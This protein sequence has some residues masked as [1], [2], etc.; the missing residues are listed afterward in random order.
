MLDTPSNSPSSAPDSISAL[1]QK[2]QTGLSGTTLTLDSSSIGVTGITNA[3]ETL[4]SS[5]SGSLV[6]D[7]VKSID[8]SP[9]RNTITLTPV[10]GDTLSATI[11]GSL[12]V[13]FASLS[14]LMEQTAIA[15]KFQTASQSISLSDLSSTYGIIP[16][17]YYG[18]T[19][20]SVFLND[21][22]LCFDSGS[23]SLGIKSSPLASLQPDFPSP[24]NSLKNVALDVLISQA[25]TTALKN[26]SVLLACTFE[27]VQGKDLTAEIYL[28]VG[29][30]GWRVS[31]VNSSDITLSDFL[32]ALQSLFSPDAL[33]YSLPAPFEALGNF[34][35]TDLEFQFSVSPAKI[36]R[37]SLQIE[38][39]NPWTIISK[40]LV[41][42]APVC[43]TL[44]IDNTHAT[45]GYSGTLTG[46]ATIANQVP[47]DVFIPIPLDSGVATISAQP[48]FSLGEGLSDL[49]ELVPE[50]FKWND[51]LPQSLLSDL[52]SLTLTDIALGIQFGAKAK[53]FPSLENFSLNID[54]TQSWSLPGLSDVSLQGVDASLDV[55]TGVN[56][57]QLGGAIQG[58]L[59]F[60]SPAIEIE[61][62]LSKPAGG[63]WS[64]SILSRDIVLPSLAQLESFVVGGS[65]PSS[66]LPDNSNAVSGL[67][68]DDLALDLSGGALQSFSFAL[69]EGGADSSWVILEH[70]FSIN[71]IYCSLNMEGDTTNGYIVAAATIL[72]AQVTF[73]AKYDSTESQW[74]FT[75]STGQINIGQFIAKLST[76]FSISLPSWINGIQIDSIDITFNSKT[77]GF[78]FDVLAALNDDYRAPELS[79]NVS[80]T[81]SGD[82][83]TKDFQGTITIPTQPANTVFTIEAEQSQGTKVEASYTGNGFSID[84]IGNL[85]D[86]PVTEIP[87]S[88]DL[89]L[90]DVTLSYDSS[91]H[92][93]FIGATNA[94]SGSAALLRMKLDVLTTFFLL[95][96][97]KSFSLSDLPLVGSELASIEN[98]EVN[99][100]ELLVTSA[101]T[102]S[103]DNIT[104]VNTTIN[105]FGTH[106]PV[107]PTPQ[108][109]SIDGKVTLAASLA[110]GGQIMHEVFSL[111]QQRQQQIPIN[112]VPDAVHTKTVA[113][114]AAA[115]GNN[116]TSRSLSDGTK[117]F[118]V[119]KSFGP[120]LIQKIGVRYN[121]GNQAL[122][123][124]IDSTL[125]AGPVALRLIGLGIGS[126]L[127]SFSPVFSLDGIG[128]SYDKPPLGISGTLI[129]AT[130]PGGDLAFEGEVTVGT[131]SFV[132]QCFG[133]YGEQSNF[134]SMFIFGDLSYPFGGPPSFFVNGAALGFGYNSNLRNPTMQDLSSFPFLEALPLSNAPGPNLFGNNPQ[135][136]QV[137]NDLM[138]GGSS[139]PWVSPV[140]SD[141]WFAGGITFNSFKLVNSEAMLLV[142]DGNELVLSL[143]GK[144]KASFP[145][146]SDTPY[147]QIE[148]DF[149]VTCT[150][151]QGTFSA[152]ALLS[153]NS[154]LF[155]PACVMTGGF[156]FD[157]WFGDNPHSGDFVLTLGGYNPMFVAPAYYPSVPQV[158]FHWPMDSSITIQGGAYFAM[159]PAVMM[160]GGVLD[161]SYQSGNLHAWFDAHADV[162]IQWKPF[163]FDA[164]I[165]IS[166]GASYRIDL[167][168][169]SF[170]VSIELSCGLELWGPPTGGQ[171]HVDWYIISFSIP[172]GNSN[173]RDTTT[174]TWSDVQA[175]LPVSGKSGT[176]STITPVA[177]LQAKATS[178]SN[179]PAAHPHHATEELES[180]PADPK[181]WVVRPSTFAFSTNVPVPSSQLTVGSSHSFEGDAVS[182]RP[183]NTSATSNDWHNI[184][185][186]HTITITASGHDRSSDFRVSLRRQNMPHSLWGDETGSTTSV[187]SG[188]EQM[189]AGQI[190]GATVRANPPTIG[191]SSGPVNV[192]GALAH[193]YLDISGATLPLEG[194]A[195]ATGVV[196]SNSQN[197]ISTMNNA[198]TGIASSGVVTLRQEILHDLKTIGY[199][200][201]TNNDSMEN[202]VRDIGNN[203]SS[204]PLLISQG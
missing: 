60:G 84:E 190:T 97:K 150:P 77:R 3:F 146:E 66:Y 130:P 181:P 91:K 17:S 193:D 202:F 184:T 18:S 44:Y 174:L 56:G 203:F 59:C 75:G 138:Q 27:L 53:D 180:A 55:T 7:N 23:L 137:L 48:G 119:Q 24:L 1:A 58:T 125:K 67:V 160:F 62:Q 143:V 159:T 45:L 108:S 198:K 167:L 176:L 38:T 89:T 140:D 70:Y 54:A 148:L 191:C 30:M 121:S 81:H 87:S 151:D 170:T 43:L 4:L 12:Q 71:D 40:K 196:P 20:P 79:L 16:K 65:S 200:P 158:G 177:G 99:D 29:L 42:D 49:A 204:E 13:T 19:F 192:L 123:F 69:T 171:V 189:V 115:S 26:Y 34:S 142:E 106:Y 90:T 14:F 51:H 134:T 104:A 28:P 11:F 201:D 163:W 92:A 35:V 166:V 64:L 118:T 122:V 68:I 152:M 93:F 86:L 162:L 10:N 74:L 117:W 186:V 36:Q 147:A 9:G 101:A 133:F 32:S 149:E 37:V 145:Q 47:A 197:S 124:E 109:G 31:V 95:D 5:K 112:P 41:I 103:S 161:A 126:P 139:L 63:Q 155:D 100:F 15:L 83:Y 6:V 129:N 131:D 128:I 46:S 57:V 107:I 113:S 105:S 195:S 187:P 111:G 76:D 110:F 165:G 175:M 114:P 22:V 132:V 156:A 2:L 39:T 182:V 154:Y 98:I 96:I 157:V 179:T 88:L 116:V 168:F 78:T 85:L 94:T 183:L 178:P 185:S 135:P 52:G 144:S 82:T 194:Y 173:Q 136:Q 25:S 164:S 8:Y 33:E 199:A 188:S 72:G 169:T 153:S 102:L 50:G 127:S 73:T 21:V 61:A 141:L 120:L 80:L 172:F